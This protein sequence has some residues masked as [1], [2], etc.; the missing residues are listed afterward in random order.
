[1]S[2]RNLFTR[3]NE[4]S[5]L[6]TE[7]IVMNQPAG[8]ED[9]MV[10]DLVDLF[11][12]LWDK[13]WYIILY[14]LFFATI[15]N[16]ISYFMIAPTY[17]TTA[18]LY[19]VSNEN[20]EDNA[21]NIT[22]LNTGTILINDYQEMILSWQVLEQVIEELNLDIDYEELS[23]MIEITNPDNTRILNLTVTSK[24]PQEAQNIAN[25]LAIVCRDYL[26]EKMGTTELNIAQ[27]ADLPLKKAGPS[28]GKF[29]LIGAFLGILG[30]AG[31]F[32][33]EY[34]MDDTIRSDEDMEKYFGLTPLTSIPEDK[35]FSPDDR[36]MEQLN[37][38]NKKQKNKRKSRRGKH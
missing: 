21:A 20:S 27:E 34:I 36:I 4:N 8:S 14:C 29:T 24:D 15:F 13:V 5:P 38:K 26:P 7:Q 25:S 30:S 9:E 23:E 6:Q 12:H 18:K 16:A 11:Y 31:V 10:I 28:C 3:D 19:V 33:I 37:K 32:I 2:E 22:D 35:N 17:E 1:M